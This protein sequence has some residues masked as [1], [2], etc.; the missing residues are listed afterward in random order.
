V[1][2]C[3]R[4]TI[5]GWG[6]DAAT[7][8]L[9]AA[10]AHA[11][12]SVEFVGPIFGEAKQRLLESAHFTILPSLCEGLPMSVL[13]GWAM[14][15]PA[16]MSAEC[17]LPEGYCAGAAIDCGVSAEQISAALEQALGIGHAEWQA[18]SSAALA[19]A[20]GPFSA[21]EVTARWAAVYSNAM[22]PVG[23]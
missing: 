2:K 19:L 9:Q 23:L 15:A 16:I 13:E 6:D 14:G 1:V 8:A 17:N 4:L 7:A 3:A 21:N 22:S 18:M 5:A 12:P 20:S 10:L 11:P